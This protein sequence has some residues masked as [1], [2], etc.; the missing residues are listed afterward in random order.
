MV[1][2]MERLKRSIFS[3]WFLLVCIVFVSA[4]FASYYY[5]TVFGSQLSPNSSDWSAFGSYFGGV[6]GP[7]ISFCTLLAVLKTV[8]LQRELLDVQAGE[9]L[10]LEKHQILA[11]S[12]QEEQIGIAKSEL[13]ISKAQAYLSTQLELLETLRDH[14]RREADGMGYAAIKILENE[15]FSAQRQ[16]LAE[17]PIRKKE[18]AEQK[19]ADLIALSL[20]LSVLRYTTV[21]EISK[22]SGPKMLN[23]IYREED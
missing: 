16:K 20:E 22:V 2:G 23:I 5:W 4:I 12:K 10:K 14:F 19:V 3:F 7:L 18:I 15:G 9:F 1:T 17:E 13:E 6:F 21:D 8:Y 11:L